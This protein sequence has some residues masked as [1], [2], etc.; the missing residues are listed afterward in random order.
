[1]KCNPADIAPDVG[2]YLR[3]LETLPWFLNLGE[4]H[5]RDHDVVRIH[6]WEEWPGPERGYGDWFGRWQAVVREQVEASEPARRA[7]LDKLWQSIERTVVSRAAAKVP[8]Y[9]PEQDAWYG[10]TV[11]VWYA[12]YTACLV[13]WHI[14][15]NRRLPERLA[16]EWEWYVDGRWPCDY[17]EEPPGYCNRSAVDVPVGKLLV[18]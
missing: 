17:A 11:C 4:P 9:D 15:L 8:M 6:T 18:F 14:L 2:G 7:E 1:M 13:G 16:A 3:L 12:A 10:P 5:P